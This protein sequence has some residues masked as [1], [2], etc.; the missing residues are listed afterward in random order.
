LAHL[1]DISRHLPDALRDRPTVHRFQGNNFQ[2][3][4]IERT[5]YEIRR[6]AQTLSPLSN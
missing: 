1:Q 5:L 6:F 4:Q 2:Y 3:Q